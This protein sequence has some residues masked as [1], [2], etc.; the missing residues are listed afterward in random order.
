MSCSWQMIVQISKWFIGMSGEPLGE[1]GQG[2][3]EEF[4]NFGAVERGVGGTGRAVVILEGAGFEFGFELRPAG[5]EQLGNLP[6]GKA[7]GTSQMMEAELVAGGEFPD[8]AG[9]GDDGNG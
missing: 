8:G 9:G 5:G 2:K 7:F 6:A 4:L 3:A 1:A